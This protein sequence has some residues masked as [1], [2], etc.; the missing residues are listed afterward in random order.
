MGA[1]ENLVGVPHRAAA[2]RPRRYTWLLGYEFPE[3]IIAVCF[4]AVVILTSKKK[5][6]HLE[7]L[8]LDCIKVDAGQR[9]ALDT[10][11]PSRRGSSAAFAAIDLRRNRSSKRPRRSSTRSIA[12][13]KATQWNSSQ[14]STSRPSLSSRTILTPRITSSASLTPCACERGWDRWAKQ[15][16]TRARAIP[17]QA[18]GS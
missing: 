7:P 16:E 10:F 9:G 4:R 6:G 14:A 5:V 2:L 1:S 18:H 8:L 3:T 13:S 17:T 11:V 12:T 15:G